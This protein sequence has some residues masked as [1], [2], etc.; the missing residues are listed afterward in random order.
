LIS[1]KK[2]INAFERN[3]EETRETGKETK[4]LVNNSSAISVVPKNLMV[5]EKELQQDAL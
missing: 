3:T 2:G 1:P 4:N 5:E